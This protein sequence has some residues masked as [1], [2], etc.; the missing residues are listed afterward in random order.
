[1]AEAA[2]GR[3]VGFGDVMALGGSTGFGEKT[4]TPKGRR[5]AGVGGRWRQ[6]RDII[7]QRLWRPT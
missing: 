6:R 4:K 7:G 3:S 2:V 1:M 5:L